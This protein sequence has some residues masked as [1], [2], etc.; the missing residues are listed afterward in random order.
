[1]AKYALR[2][3]ALEM[4]K[5]GMSYSAIKEVLGVS[6]GTLSLW[7]REM[8]LSR[9]RIN[10]LRGSSERRIERYR[11]TRAKNQ[12]ERLKIRYQNA[13]RKV[14]HL[15][16]RELF[17]GGLM[18][19]WAEGTKAS[20][21]VVCMTNTDPSMMLFFIHWLETLGFSRDQ[22]KVR[23]HLYS[24]MNN[25]SETMY[26]SSVLDIPRAA[27]RKPYI[28]ESSADKRR[29]YKGRFGHGTCNVFISNRELYDTI[30]GGIEHISTKYG[31]AEFR[32]QV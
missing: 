17:V 25:E 3:H 24:D 32:G 11:A 29:N 26:W 7:L 31:G 16:R 21:G 18:L 6:K 4:R 9:E 8:P 19:Y 5:L 20:P 14:G 22:L 23:L 2:N 10:E 15:S 27:F 13:A 28:K 1:M 12:A 30:R